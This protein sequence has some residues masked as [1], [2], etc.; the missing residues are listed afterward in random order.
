MKNYEE[1]TELLIDLL[2]GCLEEEGYE[3]LKYSDSQKH[4]TTAYECL[5]IRRD[6]N[7]FNLMIDKR[8]TFRNP[9]NGNMVFA[10]ETFKSLAE[11]KLKK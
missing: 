3:V 4:K 8:E 1:E 6:S 11:E 7:Y 9:R 10:G 2:V 5:E